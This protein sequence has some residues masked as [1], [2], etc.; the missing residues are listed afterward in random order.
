MSYEAS[1]EF[2]FFRD[3]AIVCLARNSKLPIRQILQKKLSNFDE[4]NKFF[5]N[6]LLAN[7]KNLR[8]KL[9]TDEAWLFCTSEGKLYMAGKF[10]QNIKH[11]LQK[12]GL[13]TKPAHPNKLSQ[14]QV[15]SLLGQR[16]THQ[17]PGF[18]VILASALLGLQA[19]R[20]EEVA[21]LVKRDIDLDSRIIT[22]EKTKS[23]EPQPVPIHRDLI[24]PLK[25]Y[26]AYLKPDE[27]LFIR[28]TGTRWNRKDVHYAVLKIAKRCGLA[29]INPR[30]LRTTVAHEMAS[31]G[32]AYNV[33]SR[34]LRHSDEATAPRHYLV[35]R[36]T[37][38]AR[39]ALDHFHPVSNQIDEMDV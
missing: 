11:M 22:L 2:R 36:G 1:T 29:K 6:D 17:R 39:T 8:D 24:R 30:R 34:V 23:Q 12:A 21:G 16:F 35:L 10:T 9:I 4:L 33:I 19:M 18:Q 7:Y 37:E 27:P 15:E 25:A 26:I 5:T 38:E 31:A 28:T 14:A 20:P 3:M 32:V 13:P